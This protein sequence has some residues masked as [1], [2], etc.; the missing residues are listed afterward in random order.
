MNIDKKA[1]IEGSLK[2]IVGQIP[3]VGPA[4]NEILYDYRARIK[5]NRLNSFVELLYDYFSKID[6][7]EIN[8]ESLTTEEFTDFFEMIIRKA[9][10]TKSKDRLEKLK[11]VLVNEIISP[12]KGDFKETFV[13]IVLMLQ[14]KQIE[15]LKC[16]SLIPSEVVELRGKID[17]IDLSSTLNPEKFDFDM[18]FMNEKND[19]YL[20]NKEIKRQKLE[21]SEMASEREK[22]GLL[23]EIEKY[24]QYRKPEFYKLSK[25]EFTFFVQDMISKALMYDSGIGSHF[26][27]KPMVEFS[28]TEYGKEFLSFLNQPE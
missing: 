27:S 14:N 3:I 12:Y 17:M 16:H 18:D 15:I 24:A 20:L 28:I 6:S 9:A 19:E 25:T 11:Q 21:E 23:I 1:A 4:F 26:D 8:L 13:N 5:Q 7:D 2:S 22:E 10:E